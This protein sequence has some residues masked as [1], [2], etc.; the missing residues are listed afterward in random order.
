M[1]LL[2]FTNSISRY[3]KIQRGDSKKNNYRLN[4]TIAGNQ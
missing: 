2:A 3:K 4:T 1:S